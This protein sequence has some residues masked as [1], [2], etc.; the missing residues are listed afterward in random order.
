MSR[1]AAGQAAATG[2]A[3]T[4][5]GRADQVAHARHAVA[6]HLSACGCPA[7]VIDDAVLVLSELASNAVL[8]SRS[9]GEFFT[10][11]AELQPG[12]CRLECQDGGGPWRPRR[13]DNRPHGLSVVEALTGPDGWGTQTT[14]DGNRLVWARLAW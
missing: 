10:I 14:G 5:P 6:R 8:H 9:R 11:R 3:G 13:Q 4:F 7:V 12:H 2:Y 1:A